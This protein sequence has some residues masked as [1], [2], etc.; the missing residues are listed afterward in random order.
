MRDKVRI[1]II[2][3]KKKKQNDVQTVKMGRKIFADKLKTKTKVKIT[4]DENR[5]N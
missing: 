4:K 5:T 1:I 2:K 3:R